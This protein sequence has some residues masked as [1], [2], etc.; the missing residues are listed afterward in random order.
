MTAI[1]FPNSPSVN[2]THTVG[3]RVWKWNGTVWEVVRS[4]VPYATGATGAVGQTGPTGGTGA[5]GST[6][7]GPTG[8]ASAILAINNDTGT[9]YTLQ[10]IDVNDLVTLNNANAVTV[11]VPPSV[12]SANDVINISQI[13]AGQVTFAQGAGVTINSTGA[14]ATAPKL[15]VRYSSA[16]VICTA[17]NTFLIVGDI[18]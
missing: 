10:A 11:T 3:N 17:S 12:F 18:S 4:T 7:T 14:T 15:R 8:A 6:V 13:G 5:T 2:D 1:D 9:A 16:A